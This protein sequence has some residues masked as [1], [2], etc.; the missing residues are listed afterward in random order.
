LF[1]ELK[2][3][4]KRSHGPR[5]GTRKKISRRKRERGLS[6]IS[7]HLQKFEIG[8]KVNI[9][10]D[11]SVHKGQ[12]YHRFHGHTGEV[13]GTQGTSFVVKVM[14][15]NKSKLR[16]IAPAHLKPFS[17]EKKPEKVWRRRVKKHHETKPRKKIVKKA[18]VKE[19]PE[20][21]SEGEELRKVKA[22]EEAAKEPVEKE[23]KGEEET[24]DILEVF[25]EEESVFEIIEE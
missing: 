15:G 8:Q 3:M 21:K 5:Q 22:T 17:Q 11:P 19:T 16:L 24:F 23:D 1:M 14:D 6:P 20:K 7:R 18:E 9:I 10:I 2:D 12:P 13:V 25:E 4:V